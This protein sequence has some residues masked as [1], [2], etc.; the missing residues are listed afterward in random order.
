MHF[1]LFVA[2][3]H[4]TIMQIYAATLQFAVCKGMWLIM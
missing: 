4:S 2:I 1:L 3:V